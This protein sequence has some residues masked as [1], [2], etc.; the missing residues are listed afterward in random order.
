MAQHKKIKITN[1]YQIK[2]NN[3]FDAIKSIVW[4][5]G[6]DEDIQ[7][8]IQD[9]KEDD[10]SANKYW[11]I[12]SSSNTDLVEVH[13]IAMIIVLMFGEYGT[14]PRGGWIHDEQDRKEAIAFLEELIKEKED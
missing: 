2:Y 5:N 14:S 6:L 11:W 9:L 10:F 7:Q 13:F 1:P 3:L 4:Y 8:M 12:G